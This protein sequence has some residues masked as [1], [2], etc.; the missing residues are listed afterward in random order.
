MW[1]YK[2]K[3]KED[4]GIDYECNSTSKASSWEAFYLRKGHIGNAMLK[5]LSQVLIDY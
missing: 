2:M 4:N 5:S 1:K 3:V